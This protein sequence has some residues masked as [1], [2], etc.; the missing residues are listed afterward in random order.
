MLRRIVWAGLA[1]LCLASAAYA[2]RPETYDKLIAAHAAA[3]GV[4]ESLVHRV[5]VRESRYNPRLIGHCG[6][7]GL[8]QIKLGTARSLGYEGN[9]QGLLDPETN[10]TYGVKYLAGAY[11]TAGGNPDRA[12]AY[13]AAGYYYAAKHQHVALQ[14]PGDARPTPHRSEGIL[15]LPE[16]SRVENE[17]K[18]V[19]VTRTAAM[20]RTR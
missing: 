7:L 20:S 14:M 19:R 17:K 4:P 18:P 5:I 6:C 8:M 1:L 11:R 10:L 3:N 13:Y 12:V 2:E 9:A 15:G 16:E